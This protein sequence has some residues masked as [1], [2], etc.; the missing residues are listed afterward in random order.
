MEIF[1][2]VEHAAIKYT[3]LMTQILCLW[4]TS[5]DNKR[6]KEERKKKKALAQTALRMHRND[7]SFES[8]VSLER[9]RGSS[10]HL[11]RSSQRGVV[12]LWLILRTGTLIDETL[13]DM[14]YSSDALNHCVDAA[15]LFSVVGFIVTTH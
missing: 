1:E 14:S 6:S 5:K 3:G 13:G 9:F 10:L 7:S 8:K 11:W 4:N 2:P 15:R 12:V